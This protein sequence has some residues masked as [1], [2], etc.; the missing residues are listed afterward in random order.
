MW[1]HKTGGSLVIFISDLLPPC[2]NRTAEIREKAPEQ[3]ASAPSILGPLMSQ[4]R[5]LMMSCVLHGLLCLSRCP[6]C[7][8]P[9][10]ACYSGRHA[11]SFLSARYAISFLLCIA[12]AVCWVS[13][14]SSVQS[15]MRDVDMVSSEKCLMSPTPLFCI[16][17]CLSIQINSLPEFR[18]V[19][20][21]D[22]KARGALCPK[23]SVSRFLA[24]CFSFRVMRNKGISG[25]GAIDKG[26]PV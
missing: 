25:E 10:G 13:T 20:A 9:W 19:V 26:L 16:E 4:W 22:Q 21:T 14:V 8:P 2:V 24:K 1:L 15:T 12:F 6:S 23:S 3:H 18:K 11:S 7:L 17:A 5:W